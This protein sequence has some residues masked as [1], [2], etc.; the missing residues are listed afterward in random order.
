MSDTATQKA[1]S[2]PATEKSKAEGSATRIARWDPVD[3]LET[4]QNEMSRLWTQTWPL[5]PWTMSRPL[6][7]MVPM[8]TIWAPRMDVFE[9]DGK[10]VIKTE[11]PGVKR[12]D[13]EITLD[14]DDL[15]IKG[16]RKAESEVKEEDYYRLERSQGAFYRSM[17]LPFAAKP[18]DVSARFTDGV[19]EL[20]I[21][22][23]AV[24]APEA[25][26]IAIA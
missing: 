18:E 10:L 25:K 5:G 1:G 4:L 19:L 2:G 8:P 6:R 17:T 16:E 22:K 26:K 13:V 15:T 9:K 3:M 21:P 23:P 20:E 12:E 24:K 7:R 11:L 14:G